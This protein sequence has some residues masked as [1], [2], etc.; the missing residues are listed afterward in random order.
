MLLDWLVFCECVFHSVCPLIEKDKMLME[1]SLWERLPEGDP[2]SCSD[3]WD[4]AQ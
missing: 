1:A 4:H 2:G 3:G